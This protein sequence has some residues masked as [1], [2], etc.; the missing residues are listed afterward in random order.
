MSRGKTLSRLLLLTAFAV[1]LTIYAGS[2]VLNEQS[3]TGLGVAFASGAAAEDASTLFFNPAGIVLLDRG[4]LQLGTNVVI[5]SAQ[6][7]NEGTR[8]NLPGTPFNG[9]LIAGNNGGDGGVTHIIPNL[10]LTQP[11]FRNNG[12]GDLSIGFG[13]SAPF[14]LETDYDPGWVGRYASLRSKLVTI[15]IQPTI[16]YRLFNRLSFG[17]SVDVQRAS[18]RLTQAIDFGLASRNSLVMIGPWALPLVRCLN[19]ERTTIATH[20]SRMAESVSV[21]VLQLIIAWMDT[22]TSATCL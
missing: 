13:L 12:Y 9:L 20:F 11:V 5:P 18:G 14:G 10:Y 6:F 19:I 3:V 15:D 4:E 1:P 2:F 7:R 22:L 8:Y 16:S 17:A 21:I